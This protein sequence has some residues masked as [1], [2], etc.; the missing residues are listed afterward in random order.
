[1]TDECV[2][3]TGARDAAKTKGR[4]CSILAPEWISGTVER[5]V[6][7]LPSGGDTNDTNHVCR[8]IGVIPN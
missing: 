5:G 7:R 4:V 3:Y 6:E 2:A 1:M 8:E